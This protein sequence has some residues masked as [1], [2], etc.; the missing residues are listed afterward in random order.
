ME[1]AEYFQNRIK[2]ISQSLSR[3][4]K[5]S[6]LLSLLRLVVF[7][8]AVLIAYFFWGNTTIVAVSLITG[9]GGFL[10]LVARYTDIKHK[11][12]FHKKLVEL[13]EAEL[14]S[15]NR[16]HED[17]DGGK[18]FLNGDHF[19]N[20]DIDLFG[21]GSIFQLLNR[22][23]TEN[24]KKTLA[25]LL[26]SNDIDNIHKKQEAIK[27]LAIISNWR[28]NFQVT[29]SMIENEVETKGVIS[30]IK[31]YK[32]AIPKLFSLVPFIFSIASL[33]V[34]VLYGL[35][36]IQ[37]GIVVLWFFTG[38]LITMIFFKKINVLY[39]DAGKMR[40]TFSQYS[41]MIAAI[42]NE[43]FKS[44][45]LVD[46]KN[47]LA[48][49]GVAASEVLGKLSKEINN[50][51]QRNNIIFGILANGFL[52]WDLRYS[53]RIEK[54]MSDNEAAIEK[55]FESVATFDAYN[56]LG[57]YAFIHTAHIYPNLVD[58]NTIIKAK[59]LGHPL[60]DPNKRVDN[61]I[62]I[63]KGNFFIVTGA[64][65]AGKSTFLRTTAL[66]IVM[67]NCG[68]PIC[69]KS[70]DYHPIKLISSMRTSDSLQDDESYF[71]SELK[72]LKFIVDQIKQDTYFIIL[73]EIL[74]GTNSKDKAEGSKKFVQ[75][76]VASHSTGLIATH[77]LSLCTLADE[78]AEVK[79]HYFDAQIIND[80]LYFDYQFKDG[81]CQNM[82][83]SFLLKKM[84]IV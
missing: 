74:K 13:N 4:K 7:V 39:A 14:K 21:R 5:T 80:E 72:R 56:G 51:D 47:E 69:A 34:F 43:E 20:S 28:Q 6:L 78:Y 33:A 40:E 57:N 71:F 53:Y 25:N 45:L 84:E 37:L 48:T 81:V 1:A 64:N 55:W 75:K 76:L 41:K 36:M 67:A 3:L 16:N 27:E 68:L 62:E 35:E 54:W 79:N 15:L 2:T 44:Q 61:D 60:L 9:F 30:W 31:S 18:E 17:F 24:G 63:G 29:A 73:D 50:L 83:A 32:H 38:L 42:E 58:D 70:F 8:S 77:D 52:L 23:G 82:N 22:A 10:F 65:M 46:L 66:S 19:F 12:D 59:A 49:D 26:N 11:R